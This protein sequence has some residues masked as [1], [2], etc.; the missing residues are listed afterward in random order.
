MWPCTRKPGICQKI[1][2]IGLLRL[3]QRIIHPRCPTKFED[4]RPFVYRATAIFF[5]S[6]PTSSIHKTKRFL[7]TWS[8]SVILI[9]YT[10][11][12]LRVRVK[13]HVTLCLGRRFFLLVFR[14][15]SSRIH[16]VWVSEKLPDDIP[17]Y[18]SSITRGKILH[19]SVFFVP[20]RDDLVSMCFY[21]AE[22]LCRLCG[23][24]FLF[25]RAWGWR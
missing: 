1:T 19:G 9:R 13:G 20:L 5:R 14:L 3:S 10:L 25:S 11:Q 16:S 6:V 22:V 17:A 15:L 23:Y 8:F 21:G 12:W 2:I 7:V 4:Y 18:L 24:L